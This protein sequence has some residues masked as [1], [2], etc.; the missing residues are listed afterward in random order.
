MSTGRGTATSLPKSL[1]PL[2]KQLGL[3]HGGIYSDVDE[4]VASVATATA[5]L[6]DGMTVSGLSNSAQFLRPV[7]LGTVRVN[8]RCRHHNEREW[9]WSQE[10]RDG[11]Q[12]LCAIVD[13]WIAVRPSRA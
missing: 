10:F 7:T 5:V 13:V 6:R 12:R 8:A 2:E 1:L 11:R 4:T 3:V 9:Q